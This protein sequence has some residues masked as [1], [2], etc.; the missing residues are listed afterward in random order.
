MYNSNMCAEFIR[1]YCGFSEETKISIFQIF[2]EKVRKNR[3][4]KK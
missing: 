1:L 2:S 4:Y 3:K